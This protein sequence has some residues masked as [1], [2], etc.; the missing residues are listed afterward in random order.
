MINSL[1]YC[2]QLNS[3]QYRIHYRLSKLLVSSS[4]ICYC[5]RKCEKLVFIQLVATSFIKKKCTLGKHNNNKFV[6]LSYDHTDDTTQCTMLY[7][8]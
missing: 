5:E 8:M 4:I 3:D 1:K 7:I 2:H 6:R